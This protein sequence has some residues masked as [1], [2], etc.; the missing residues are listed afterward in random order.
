MYCMTSELG[1]N[2]KFGVNTII[3]LIYIKSSGLSLLEP[4]KNNVSNP[5]TYSEPCHTSKMECFAKTVND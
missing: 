2:S 4:G 5:E 3:S 1:E